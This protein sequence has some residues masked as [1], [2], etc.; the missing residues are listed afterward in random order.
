[1]DAGCSGRAGP[2]SDQ[3]QPK[4]VS[5]LAIFPVDDCLDLLEGEIRIGISKLRQ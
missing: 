5:G 4:R 2:S 1:M 3:C